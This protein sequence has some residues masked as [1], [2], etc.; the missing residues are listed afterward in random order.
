[1]SIFGLIY[2]LLFWLLGLFVRIWVVYIWAAYCGFNILFYF[3]YRRA[4]KPHWVAFGL[5]S[6][7][8]L[9]IGLLFQRGSIFD[10]EIKADEIKGAIFFFLAIILSMANLAALTKL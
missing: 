6:Y 10:Q 5:I 2:N 3:Y 4:D 1:M 7:Q 8:I 9:Y